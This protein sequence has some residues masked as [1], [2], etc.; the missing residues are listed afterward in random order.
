MNSTMEYVGATVAGSNTTPSP[1]R[2]GPVVIVDDDTADAVLAEGVI[3]E[4][5]PRFPVQILTSGEDLISYLEGRDLYSDRSRYPYPSLVLLDLKMP[6]MDGFE[7]LKWLKRHPEHAE[8]PI[9][10]LSGRFDMPGQ[11]TRACQLGALS[12]LPKPVQQL[13]IQ[14][15]LSLLKIAI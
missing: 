2:E 7:V 4:L 12:F 6:G 15:I 5:R 8:V 13:D 1:A 9:V 14:S 10:V 3:D 11:V